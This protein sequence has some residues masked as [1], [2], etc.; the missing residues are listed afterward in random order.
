MTA[1]RYDF[2]LGVFK[3]LSLALCLFVL[4]GMSGSYAHYYFEPSP[5][6][7]AVPIALG[8]L[9]VAP[10]I[11]STRRLI[12][13]FLLG[14]WLA[15]FLRSAFDK[16]FVYD[17]PINAFPEIRYF[18]YGLILGVPFLVVA[19]KAVSALGPIKLTVLTGFLIVLAY[20]VLNLVYAY[21][22]FGMYVRLGLGMWARSDDTI[23]SRYFEVWLQ[24]FDWIGFRLITYIGLGYLLA[25]RKGLLVGMA[26]GSLIALADNVLGWLVFLPHDGEFEAA[27]LSFVL[28]YYSAELLKTLLA[29]VSVLSVFVVF[30]AL[31]MLVRWPRVIYPPLR[32]VPVT[33]AKR[34]PHISRPVPPFSLFLTQ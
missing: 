23:W 21:D 31:V 7:C 20:H 32:A 34:R 29:Q 6:Y 4:M 9:V 15:L 3:A 10:V 28:D 12:P 11:P 24:Y 16:L 27:P 18:I 19:S 14:C 30:G 33:K 1:K 17:Y 5:Y 2:V 8:L 22:W 25:K 13:R 26:I